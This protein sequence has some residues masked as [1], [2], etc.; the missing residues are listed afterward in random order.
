MRTT[1]GLERLVTFV[2]AIVAIA[3]TLLVLPLVDLAV[4]GTNREAVAHHVLGASFGQLGTFLLSF[5]VIARLWAGHHAMFERVR[6]YDGALLFWTLAWALS[7]VFLPFPTELVANTSHD[8][9]VRELY[10]GTMAF[11][12]ICLSALAILIAR[13]PVLRGGPHSPPF[14]T[15][16]PISSMLLFL[17]AM[18][19][20]TVSQINYF[21]LLVLAFD[22]LVV[23]WWRRVR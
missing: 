20:T 5:A 8:L 6:A 15:E 14:T 11:S 18:A 7:I 12:S 9:A 23:K 4:A 2:D 21:A 10:I 16:A 13:R 19:L 17:L 1:R 22:G 3:I